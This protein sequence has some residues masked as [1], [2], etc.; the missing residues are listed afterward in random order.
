M[1]RLFYKPI[2]EDVQNENCTDAER[3]ALLDAFEHTMKHVATTLARKAWFELQDYALAKKQ[4]IDG[5]SL[6]IERENV[7]GQDHWT[8][9]FENGEKSLKVIGTLERD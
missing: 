9:V 4:G 7:L 5:F 1:S 2:I 8:G 6:M 3:E